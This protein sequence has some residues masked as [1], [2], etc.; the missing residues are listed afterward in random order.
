[1]SSSTNRAIKIADFDIKIFI[2]NCYT[3]Y[4]V[5]RLLHCPRLDDIVM[6]CMQLYTD[7]NLV[8]PLMNKGEFDMRSIVS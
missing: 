1:M 3:D 5:T 6:R 4:T 8:L 2:S 7:K